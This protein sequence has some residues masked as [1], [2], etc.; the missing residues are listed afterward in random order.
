LIDGDELATLMIDH[1]VGV[2][3]D[4]SYKV[5]KLDENFFDN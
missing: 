1:E 5:Y 4:K 2:T 3:A